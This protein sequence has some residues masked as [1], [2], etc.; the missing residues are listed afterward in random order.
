MNYYKEKKIVIRLPSSMYI[1][2]LFFLHLLP[3]LSPW[4][5]VYFCRCI[6]LF[7]AAR[8]CFCTFQFLPS[9][10]SSRA[11]SSGASSEAPLCCWIVCWDLEKK[12]FIKKCVVFF[13]TRKKRSNFDRRILGRI[14]G[15]ASLLCTSNTTLGKYRVFNKYRFA[16]YYLYGNTSVPWEIYK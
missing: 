14:E 13:N 6:W 9:S 10:H 2:I 11:V 3:A 16:E 15:R 8:D 5:W 7:A 12:K 4:E 1:F